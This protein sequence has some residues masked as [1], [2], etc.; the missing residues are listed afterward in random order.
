MCVCVCD[1]LISFS[2]YSVRDCVRGLVGL[3]VWVCMCVC[4]ITPAC[5]QRDVSYHETK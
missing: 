5:L 4:V 1:H 2:N 3:G